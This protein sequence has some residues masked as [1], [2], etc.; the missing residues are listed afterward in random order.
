MRKRFWW[1]ALGLLL[2]GAGMSFVAIHPHEPSYQGRLLSRWLEDCDMDKTQLGVFAEAAV[3]QIGPES[4]RT[5]IRLLEKRDNQLKR[6]VMGN[7]LEFRT[8]GFR[9]TSAPCYQVRAAAACRVLGAKAE[10]AVPALIAL[11]P[12]AVAGRSAGEALAAVGPKAMVALRGQLTNELARSRG[13]AAGALLRFGTNA[14]PAIP[15][16]VVAGQDADATVRLNAVETLGT[17]GSEGGRLVIDG[18][19]RAL[20]DDD[21]LVRRCGVAFLASLGTRAKGAAPAV[22]ALVHDSDPEVSRLVPIA[23]RR[24]EAQRGEEEFK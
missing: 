12:E 18:L 6:R 20:R 10:A 19:T 11:L 13:A 1:L 4:I 5:L 3:R 8:L 9:V 24:M 17:I 16:L 2:I 23:L 22:A 15:A 14:L 7:C 21:A